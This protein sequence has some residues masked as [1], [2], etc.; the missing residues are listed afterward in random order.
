[1]P[2]SQEQQRTYRQQRRANPYHRRDEQN[3]DTIRRREARHREGE[4]GV[5]VDNGQR[6]RQRDSPGSQSRLRPH[7]RDDHAPW[8]DQFH[9]FHRRSRWNP[10]SWNRTCP[11][12]GA[13]LLGGEPLG[14]CCNDGKK[15]VPPLPALPPRLSSIISSPELSGGR[16]SS[17][18]R[19]FNNLFSFTAIGATQ[20]FAHFQ[21]G[22]ASVAITGRTYH[23]VLDVST[24]NHSF[25]WFLYDETERDTHGRIWEVPDSWTHNFR[26]DLQEVNPYVRNL[27]QFHHVSNDSTHVLELRDTSSNGDFAAIMHAANSTTIHPRSVLIWR[28]SDEQPSF[29]SILTPLYEPLQYPVLFPHGTRG[30]GLTA[31]DPEH[32]ERVSNTLGFTQREWYKGRILTEDRFLIFGRLC[33]EYLCD[34]YSRMEEERLNYIRRSRMSRA[35][36]LDPSVD[37][38][39][40][41]IELPASFLGSRKWA[42]EETADS[43]ALARTFGKPSYFITMTCNPEWPE[44]TSRLRPGQ[45]ASDVPVIVARVFKIRLQRLLHMIRRRFGDLIYMVIVREF[46]KRGLPHAHIILK[47]M[48]TDYQKTSMS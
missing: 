17:T 4:G 45:N 32:P 19:R 25:H 26:L 41:D 9:D 7:R 40:I 13:L 29:V 10:P 39:N 42:S 3:A 23:R 11:H 31:N 24:P 8:W 34:M 6:S 16:L 15:V 30:W 38:T 14:F 18:S 12:C 5:A 43:L 28:N 1:M 33:S 46:Q 36:T 44:I 37:A 47:V 2:R 20:G 35:R 22:P 21:S 27:Q 48:F